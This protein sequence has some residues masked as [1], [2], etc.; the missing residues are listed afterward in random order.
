MFLF[1]PSL[2]QFCISLFYSC[3]F[4]EILLF[5]TVLKLIHIIVQTAFVQQFSMC[6]FFND[7]SFMQY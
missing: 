2:Y 5:F 4:A 6:A 7:L 3:F 1:L